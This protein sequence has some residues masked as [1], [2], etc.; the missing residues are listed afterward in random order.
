MENQINRTLHPLLIVDD[1][2]SIRTAIADYLRGVGFPVFEAE[3]GKEAL[4]ILEKEKIAMLITDIRMPVMDGLELI[5]RVKNEH[6]GVLYALMTAYNVD[7]YIRFA[8]KESIW[9]IIPK[10]ASL[11]LRFM[12]VMVEK[13]LSGNIFGVDKYYP[14]ITI[15][16]ICQTRIT[17]SAFKKK[18][19]S[20]LV[21]DVLYTCRVESSR[22]NH[23]MGDIIGERLKKE[24]A[25]TMI[26]QILEELAS[27]AMIRAPA[28]A[29]KTSGSSDT[30]DDDVTSLLWSKQDPSDSPIDLSFGIISGNV[31]LSVTDYHGSLDHTE[32]LFR[33]ERQIHMDT[34][35]GLPLGLT[36]FHG[37]GLF[38]CRE[39]VDQLIFNIE[40][41]KKTEV[42]A[43]MAL[44]VEDRERAISIFLSAENTINS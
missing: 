29:Q 5:R 13:L 22:E 40:P 12:R 36:D 28:A 26:R 23:R 17:A 16:S 43:I 38:I 42:I 10:S 4:E 27:N 1:I 15:Q 18:L 35:T 33:L 2:E 8:R 31:I 20:G 34:A 30:N 32:I 21:P 41:G 25:P 37:R 24:G 7:D 6:P 11:D 44:D 14:H 19:S 3:H 9:N 39:H